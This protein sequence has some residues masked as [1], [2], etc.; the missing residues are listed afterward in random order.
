M[1]LILQN[2]K[3]LVHFGA[4]GENLVL[5][6]ELQFKAAIVSLMTDLVN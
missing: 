4:G 3:V 5:R 2:N 6:A 1:W